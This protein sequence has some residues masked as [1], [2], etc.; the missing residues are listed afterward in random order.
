MPFTGTTVSVP[1]RPL[2]PIK[3]SVT[4]LAA[5]GKG[6]PLLSSTA[7]WTAGDMVAPT[8]TV[9]GCCTNANIDAWGGGMIDRDDFAT[10]LWELFR[11]ATSCRVDVSEMEMG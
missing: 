6:L 2:P 10:A 7:T 8:C 11:I 4:G 5:G 1:A 9:V 3:A